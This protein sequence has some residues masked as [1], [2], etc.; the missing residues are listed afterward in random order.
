MEEC[1]A[2]CTR[3]AIMVKG[4]FQCLGTIQHLAMYLLV[5]L[6][7]AVFLEFPLDLLYLHG[8]LVLVQGPIHLRSLF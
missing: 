7:S 3:L 1:E 6:G 2:L 4:A 8:Y 5:A